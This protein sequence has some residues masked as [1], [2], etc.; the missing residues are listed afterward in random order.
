MSREEVIDRWSRYIIPAV[1]RAEDS[2]L[3]RYPEWKERLRSVKDGDV[4][5]VSRD[6]CRAIA[7]IIVCGVFEQEESVN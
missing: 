5:S 6:Y 1:F 4:V 2:L 7:D 3:K